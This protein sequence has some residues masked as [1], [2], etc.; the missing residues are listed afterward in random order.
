M[1][2]RGTIKQ[3]IDSLQDDVATETR[4]SVCPLETGK[5]LVSHER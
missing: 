3:V 4:L 2:T 5:G 1:L